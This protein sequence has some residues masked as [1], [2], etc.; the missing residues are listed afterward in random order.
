MENAKNAG[1]FH[2]ERCDF[3]CSKRSNFEKHLLTQK[4]KI[5]SG[6]NKSS[7]NPTK[8]SP[9]FFPCNCGKKYKHR[10]TLSAHKKICKGVMQSDAA[11]ENDGVVK[12]SELDSVK[13]MFMQTMTKIAEV[14]QTQNMQAMTKIAEVVQNQSE[15]RKKTDELIVNIMEKIGNTTNNITNTNNTNNNNF[16]I[17][18]FL[19]NDCKDAINFS[20]FIDRI[21]VSRDDLENNAKLGFVEGISKIIMDNLSQLTLHERPIHC[22]DTKRDTL[23]IKNDDTWNKEKDTVKK[24]LDKSIQEVSRKSVRSL[25]DWKADN[26]E[27]YKDINSEFSNKC[28]YMQMQSMAGDNRDK[29]YPKVV[30]KVANSVALHRNKM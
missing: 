26:D 1:T 27:D 23:Y 28:I 20:D 3:V 7:E 5:L 21:E 14:V 2:C 18:M 9:Q 29:L 16:N 8:K 17:N 6:S 24:M 11:T 4:H 19:N 10:S 30:K 22:T 25:M 13:T 12:S 15:D